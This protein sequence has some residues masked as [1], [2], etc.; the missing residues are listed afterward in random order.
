M[1]EF[2]RTQLTDS[3]KKRYDVLL[4]A[5]MKQKQSVNLPAINNANEIPIICKYILSDHPELYFVSTKFTIAMSISSLTINLSYLYN[6][7][8]QYEINQ[9][10]LNFKDKLKK[11]MN[12]SDI[13][14][15][16]STIFLLMRNSR[17]VIDNIYNQNAASV[18]YYH[19]A[20]CSG[21]AS[22]FKY[23]M[24][25][26]GIWCII[27]SGNISNE[28]QNG[29]HAWNVVKID[30]NYYHIDITSLANENII[31]INQLYQYRLFESDAQKKQK[32]YI[33]NYLEIPVC[34]EM[35][36][37][38]FAKQNSCV[39]S[40]MLVQSDSNIENNKKIPIFNRLFDLQIKIIECLKK[41]IT[42]YEFLLNIPMYS[43]EKLMKIIMNYIMEQGENLSISFEVE[44]GVM[45]KKN[46]LKFNY[47]N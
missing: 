2:W 4:E 16:Y 33:W 34:S 26:M 46:Y 40:T 43:D 1:I 28:S 14:R 12:K 35:D 18:I 6:T 44:V 24:D 23:A 42:Y 3:S 45:N 39:N 22:A 17:Y 5:I 7:K 30:E 36:T 15:I 47:K 19:S 21:F 41:R 38:I 9:S 31:S 8:Q 27:V 10:F 32:G 25:L 29:P 20:Q 13:E 37:H 11:E